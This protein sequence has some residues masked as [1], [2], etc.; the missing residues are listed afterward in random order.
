M[1]LWSQCSW[2]QLRYISW[3]G[4]ALAY[5]IGQLEIAKLRKEAEQ[6]VGIKFDKCVQDCQGLTTTTPVG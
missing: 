3:P 4:Q 6:K 1:E 2:R 5:K